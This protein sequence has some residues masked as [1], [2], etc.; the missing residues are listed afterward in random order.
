MTT[1]TGR[2]R[3][4][5]ALRVRSVGKTYASNRVLNSV[6]LDVEP[7]RIH[8]L[9]GAN[10]SGKSTLV[11]ILTG[12]I[13]PDPGADLAI[14]GAAA[15]AARLRSDVVAVHQEVPLF[16]EL[17][18][19]DNIGLGMGFPTRGGW[20]RTRA[21]S[22]RVHD[23]MSSF[24]LDLDPAALVG[25]L[26]PSSRAALGLAIAL[27]G[28]DPGNAVVI[29]DESTALLPRDDANRFL[30]RCRALADN[31]A[32][33]LFVTHRL[34]EV[35]EFADAV[36]V[37]RAGRVVLD[38]DVSE[39]DDDELVGE[40]VGHDSLA[41]ALPRARTAEAGAPVLEVSGLAGERLGGVDL[42]VR[43]GEIVGVTGLVGSGADEVPALVS[44]HLA[45][46]A[47]RILIG[48]RLMPARHTSRQLHREGGAYLPSSRP[49]ESALGDFSVIDNLTLPRLVTYWFRRSLARARMS[50]VA[51]TFGLVYPGP[52]ADLSTL[53]GGNQQKV[54]LAKW[55][56]TEPSLLIL[57]DPVNGVDAGARQAIEHELAKRA[58]SGAGILLV[59]G[60]PDQL[61][62][63]CDRVVIIRDGL[64]VH[65]LTGNNLNELEI[66][67]ASQY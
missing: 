32:A 17:S 49:T 45:R 12:V 13:D 66:S 39:V 41:R 25:T 55:L 51:S 63:M 27:H 24:Q 62:R 22:S 11:K 3:D 2:S 1:A 59:S 56:L 21:L 61:V 29:L 57:H 15:S 43:G 14:A 48:G 16:D 54:L 46:R 18:I 38:K 10:G 67:H 9:L 31:G 19:A 47:G 36:T 40:I 44:G 42:T 50:E 34:Q 6:G 53:S 52:G 58:S 20:V 4:A 65:T 7:G 5:A 33:I 37:L 8:A 26:E 64:V 60:E 23:V 28:V 30:A 35:F